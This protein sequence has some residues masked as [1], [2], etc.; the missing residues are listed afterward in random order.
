MRKNN[1]YIKSILAGMFIFLIIFTFACLYITYKTGNEPTTLITCEFAFC[2]IEGGLS[3]WIRTTK[4]KKKGSE[5]TK[6]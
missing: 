2:S 3:A 5:I 1:K 4:E 6:E